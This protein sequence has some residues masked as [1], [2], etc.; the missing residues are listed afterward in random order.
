ME[1]KT[2]IRKL[3]SGD[4][5]KEVEKILALPRDEAINEI[6]RKK[7]RA[8]SRGSCSDYDYYALYSQEEF[9]SGILYLYL[10]AGVSGEDD[11]PDIPIPERGYF[12]EFGWAVYHEARIESGMIDVTEALLLKGLSIA[13]FDTEETAKKALYKCQ[14][15]GMRAERMRVFGYKQAAYSRVEDGWED[16]LAKAR[17]AIADGNKVLIACRSFRGGP[18]LDSPDI[19]TSIEI[20]TI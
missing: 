6:H 1:L 2:T 19:P 15:L 4:F 7:A 20:Y 11:L 17:K 8:S 10:A 5:K 16:M 3:E 12:D 13:A 9:W 18:T 14:E